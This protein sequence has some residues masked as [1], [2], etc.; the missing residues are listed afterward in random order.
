MAEFKLKKGLDIPIAGK[1][2]KE[3]RTIENQSIFKIH[4]VDIKGLKPK[5]L[6]KEG[7]QVKIGTPVLYNKLSEKVKFVSPAS[8]TIKNIQFGPRRVINEISIESNGNTDEYVTFESYDEQKIIELSQDEIK[9]ILLESGAW[10]YIRQRPFSKIAN[11]DNNPKSIFIS[12][13]NTSPLTPDLNFIF[14]NKNSGFQT[15]IN[16]LSKLT[17][18]KVHLS[19]SKKTDS[20]FTSVENVEIHTFNG[21]HPAGN[22]GIQIHHVDPLNLGDIVWYIDIQDVCAIGNTIQNGKFDVTKIITVGGSG[23]KSPEYIKTRRCASIG[24]FLQNNIIKD[25]KTRIISGDVLTGKIASFDHAV[26]YYHQSVTVIE[27]GGNRDFLGWISP[28][29]SHYSASNTF[30]SKLFPNNKYAFNT[31]INGS[32]RA[33]IPF[34][35]WESVLPMDLIPNYLVR[36]ILAQDIEEMEQLGIYECDEEDFALCS[37][38]C[39]SK[40]PVHT[41]IRDGLD[42]LEA[43]G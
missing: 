32:L 18:G 43:E 28:G 27:E 11:P 21:P 42:M 30:L 37:F 15:G 22:I 38:V 36:S 14:E 29:K 5:L 24:S 6:V 1:P 10:T 9:R 41:I 16:A 39:Q 12:G 7:D 17:N 26:G 2:A 34:G 33:I 4:P 40:F 20:T 3:L 25:K 19:V 23:V 8:G 35:Y 31:K 13:F